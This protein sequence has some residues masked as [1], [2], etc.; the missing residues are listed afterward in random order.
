MFSYIY[1]VVFAHLFFQLTNMK[2]PIELSATDASAASTEYK[3]LLN[4]P[5]KTVTLLLILGKDAAAIAGRN[6]VRLLLD[7]AAEAYESVAFIFVPEPT[8]LLANLKTLQVKTS[9]QNFSWNDYSTY[10]ALSISPDTNIISAFITRQ[11]LLAT[12]AEIQIAVLNAWNNSA[13]NNA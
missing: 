11:T 12:P 9:G 1:L 4:E 8:F 13:P 7:E 3:K 10:A 2:P 6:Y 5:S